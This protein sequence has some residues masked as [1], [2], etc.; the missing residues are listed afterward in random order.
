LAH[1][2]R[3]DP[4]ATPALERLAEL[5]PRASRPDRVAELRR[6]KAEIERAM[7]AYR[8][9][10]WSDEPL[11]TAA[12]R[13]GLARMAESA[14]RP[15]EARALYQWATRADPGDV[16]AR[17]GLARL[18]RA[19]VP[20]KGPLPAEVEPWTEPV[21]G[22][23]NRPQPAGPGA[24]TVGALAFTDDAEAVG[25]RFVY[26]NAETSIHQLPEPFGGGL[27]L[28]DYDGDGWLDVYCVQ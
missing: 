9:R 6:R 28:L 11:R 7:A 19:D 23:A 20:R 8:D 25:L 18:D 22:P 13:A 3:I 16:S 21:P 24:A 12:E 10:L 4:T 26:D 15:H 14:G 1:W 17:E 27:A 5:A 2:R